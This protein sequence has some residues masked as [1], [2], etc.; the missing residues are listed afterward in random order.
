ALGANPTPVAY[1]E[2]YTAL[3]TGAIDGQDNPLPNVQ[4]MKFYE[5]MDQIV[6]TSHT[7][8][9]DVLTISNS[10]WDSLTPEQQETVQAAAD[11]AIAWSTTA[12]LENEAS[13]IEYFREQGLEVY[14]PD[15]D[16]FREYAQ[17][18][19]SNSSLAD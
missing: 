10:V 15:L 18:L 7:V 16:A 6:L 8:G 9:F 11:K 12:H 1:A 13:L 19:Y 5:V 17:D 3:Q 4:N 2:V 14:E